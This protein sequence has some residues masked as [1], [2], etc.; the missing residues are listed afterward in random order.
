ML[1][2]HCLLLSDH[3]NKVDV[4]YRKHITYNYNISKKLKFKNKL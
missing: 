4:F 1:I 2:N 3:S